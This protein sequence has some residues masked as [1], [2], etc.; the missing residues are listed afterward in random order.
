MKKIGIFGGSFNPPHLG[1]LILAERI[2][3][4]LK[5]DKLIFIP[6]HIPPHKKKSSIIDPI[7]RTKMLK[8]SISGKKYFDISDI[9]IKRGGT[10]FTYDTLLELHKKYKDTLFYLVIGEDNF[11]DFC[12][13]KNYKQIF[14]LAQVVV[15][16]RAVDPENLQLKMSSGADEDCMSKTNKEITKKQFIFVDTPLMDISSTE[17]RKRVKSGKN[18]DYFV[19]P[20][21]KNYILKN[22]LYL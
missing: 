8:L 1:H 15:I 9:E 20:A 12:Y 18:I 14:K 16:K 2:V 5:L 11:K 19:T 17:I 13:W 21:V 7:H 6:A 4:K 3:E 10:S 22:K